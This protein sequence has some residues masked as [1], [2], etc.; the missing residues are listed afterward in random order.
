MIFTD[1]Q[2]LTT[3][4]VERLAL[5]PYPHHPQSIKLM[6]CVNPRDPVVLMFLSGEPV[7]TPLP[8]VA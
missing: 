4:L 8:Q 7:S 2:M 3:T 6:A 1:E 5:Y